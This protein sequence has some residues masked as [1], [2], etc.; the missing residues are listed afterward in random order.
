VTPPSGLY[1]S[2]GNQDRGTL[3]QTRVVLYVVGTER[4]FYSVGIVPLDAL[5]E[6]QRR[7]QV[8]EGVVGVKH[9]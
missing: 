1:L 6:A 7:G 4:F 9:E 3:R 8:R 5:Y 2:C